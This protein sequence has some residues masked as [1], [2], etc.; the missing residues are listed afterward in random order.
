[1]VITYL[2]W[3]VFKD[4]FPELKDAITIQIQFTALS[5][6]VGAAII[7]FYNFWRKFGVKLSITTVSH[8]GHSIIY[9]KNLKDKEIAILNLYLYIV[10]DKKTY[11]L[12]VLKSSKTDD[13]K[14]SIKAYGY[15]HLELELPVA[16][17]IESNESILGYTHIPEDSYVYIDPLVRKDF[18]D[19]PCKDNIVL[20]QLI[21]LK[22][23]GYLANTSEGRYES[24]TRVASRFFPENKL[25]F[26][27][28][29]ELVNDYCFVYNN[30]SLGCNPDNHLEIDP[31]TVSDEQLDK[32]IREHETADIPIKQSE[33]HIDFETFK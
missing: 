17:R 11:M 16:I 3:Y 21:G 18:F 7:G 28:K 25:V 8:F 2:V 27:D 24:K 10:I 1:M 14:L 22:S 29:E 12:D 4:K 32:F 26:C 30:I 19:L 15:E 13:K 20:S 23:L 33:Y 5:I 6:G 31:E 9:I